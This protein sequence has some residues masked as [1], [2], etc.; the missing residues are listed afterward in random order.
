MSLCTVMESQS[1]G[2]QKIWCPRLYVISSDDTVI[3]EQPNK[4]DN[5]VSEISPI[6]VRS[7]EGPLMTHDTDCPQEDRP[8]HCRGRAVV[9]RDGR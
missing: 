9:Y 2:A 8:L 4:M 5:T 3:M 7:Q 6:F 1:V